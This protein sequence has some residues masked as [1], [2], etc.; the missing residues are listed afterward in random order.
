MNNELLIDI[1][2]IETFTFAEDIYDSTRNNSANI[3]V[4]VLEDSDVI[5]TLHGNFYDI[6]K[7][8]FNK[9]KT[10]KSMKKK[11]KK[12]NKTILDDDTPCLLQRD[13][14]SL[15]EEKSFYEQRTLQESYNVPPSMLFDPYRKSAFLFGKAWDDCVGKLQDNDGHISIF[16]GSGSGKSSTIAIPTLATWKSP[17]FA[18]DFKG[19]L[20]ARARKRKS[21][22]L[23]M[24]EGQTKLYWYDPFYFI[25]Q[26]GNENRVQNARELAQAIIP[27]PFNVSDPFWIM[28]ARDILTSAILYYFDIG[29]AFIDAMIEIKTTSM[30]QLFATISANVTA[31]ACLN[32]D[33]DHNPKML[34]GVS[35]ELHNHIAIFATDSLVQDVLS[36]SKDTSCANIKWEQLETSDIFIRIDH[37]K[38]RQW[39]SVIRLMIT[40]LIR[41][42]ERRPE[43]YSPEG[44]NIK[45][46]LLLLDEFPQ[47]GKIDVITSALA[48]LRSK[49][50]TISLFNQSLADLDATYGKDV[51]RVI[52]D[53]CPYKAILNSA[54]AETQRY[55]SDLVGTVK[56]PAKGISTSYDELGQPLG[57]SCN[58]SESREPIIHPHEFAALQNIVLLHPYGFSRIEKLSY[59]KSS[60]PARR[61]DYVYNT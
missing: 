4:A 60:T 18:F 43:K 2:E 36:P 34:A 10:K 52:L 32:P 51:R 13:A 16:G 44:A 50:V 59:Y 58:I 47:Y 37:S 23:N 53:N 35:A 54:D 24:I 38:I 20:V 31:K 49:N 28:S 26:N 7:K 8:Y 6:Y 21:K 25:R 33:L 9:K 14:L 29:A 57:Y 30:S 27:L 19:E 46:T 45:P 12:K 5:L 55:F 17:I 41:T 61:I 22:I 15:F 39:G 3:A 56:V 11:R 48:T 1:D 42:L 40:Q